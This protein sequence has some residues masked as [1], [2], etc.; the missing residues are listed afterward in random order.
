V[1]TSLRS[2]AVA[3]L[4]LLGACSNAPTITCDLNADLCDSAAQ[5]AKSIDPGGWSS[6]RVARIHWGPCFWDKPCPFMPPAQHTEIIVELAGSDRLPDRYVLTNAH[7][8]AG[9]AECRQRANTAANAT[10]TEPCTI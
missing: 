1:G 9:T 10:A 6:F 4:V 3:S 2:L 5:T 8:D 7:A